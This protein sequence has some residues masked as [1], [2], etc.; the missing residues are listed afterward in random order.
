MNEQWMDDDLKSIDHSIDERT[1]DTKSKKFLWLIVNRPL[2]DQWS[3]WPQSA[4]WRMRNITIRILVWWWYG[5]FVIIIITSSEGWNLCFHP[6]WSVGLY[7]CPCL[8]LLSA[9]LPL[10]LPPF[11]PPPP[12]PPPCF[13]QQL[14]V[15]T[16]LKYQISMI[17]LRIMHPLGWDTMIHQVPLLSHHF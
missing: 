6:C 5:D 8:L 13:H 16:V 9:S 7:H 14:S 15:G 4:I 3:I 2:I 11:A 12:P 17:E 1:I 10:Y